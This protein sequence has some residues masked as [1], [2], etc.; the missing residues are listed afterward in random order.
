MSV[1]EY[2]TDN[3]AQFDF[4]LW[5]YAAPRSSVGKLRSINLLA[6]SFSGRPAG[7]RAMDMMRAV[8]GELGERRTVWGVKQ[9]GADIAWELYF[10]DYARTERERSIPR[11]LKTIRPWI[12]CDVE[13]REA[14]PYFMFSIEL[15]EDL[16]AGGGCLEEV[17]MYIGNIGSQ[18]SSGI[19]YGVTRQQT[20]LKNFYFF[21]DAKRE[22]AEIAGKVCSSAYI[23]ETTFQLDSVLWPELRD[24][25]IIV[26][27]NKPDRDGVYFSRITVAQLLWFMKRMEYPENQI[28]FLESN[29]ERFDH[30]LYDVGFDYRM[31]GGRLKILKSAYYGVF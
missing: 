25:Q 9:V 19:C 1:L 13:S 20:R 22:M 23:D 10:Y 11:V 8:R 15:S 7:R 12:S 21:F 16:L 24:C 14:A 2:A 31:E 4:C 17:Q 28:R 6:E 3:E 29:L 27:A 30:M 5:E 18:V 26:V